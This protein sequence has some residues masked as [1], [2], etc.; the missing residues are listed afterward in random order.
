MAG[1]WSD[2]EIETW[3]R[4]LFGLL[5]RQL[6]THLVASAQFAHTACAQVDLDAIE[7]KFHKKYNQFAEGAFWEEGE[8]ESGVEG[9]HCGFSAKCRW[10]WQATGSGVPGLRFPAGGRRSWEVARRQG[11]APVALSKSGKA[12]IY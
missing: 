11:W 5:Q 4:W 6:T 8:E 3:Q 2:A 1:P 7:H 9:F 10:E 12:G